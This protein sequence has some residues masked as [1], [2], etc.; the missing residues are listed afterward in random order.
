MP[1]SKAIQQLELQVEELTLDLQRTRAD[2]ENYRKRSEIERQQAS[3]AGRSSTIMKIIPII[4]TIDRAIGQVPVDIAENPWVKGIVALEKNLNNALEVLGVQK[5]DA[6]PGTIF[7]PELHDAVQ[8][9]EDATG[10]HEVI[11]EELQSGYTLNGRPIRHA[12]V[13]VTRQ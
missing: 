9:D 6:S 10:E 4:D 11:A 5:I 7:N 12:M 1:K 8:M 3:D 13:K 2:F